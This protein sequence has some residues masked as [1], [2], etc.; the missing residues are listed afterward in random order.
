MT[1]WVRENDGPPFQGPFTLAEVAAGV[2]AGQFSPGCELLEAQGQSYGALIRATGWRPLRD[3]N[4]SNVPQI[5]PPLSP[6]PNVPDHALARGLVV[7]LRGI[8]VLTALW[9]LLNILSAVQTAAVVSRTKQAGGGMSAQLAQATQSAAQMAIFT[10]VLHGAI[11][12]ML[13][14]VLSEGLKLLLAIESNTRKRME[15]ETLSKQGDGSHA[16][17]HQ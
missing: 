7:V 17:G 12:V 5:A 11:L 3:F 14:L 13:P 4:L 15:P 9:A 2:R 1:F 16:G 8:A 10:A 6:R